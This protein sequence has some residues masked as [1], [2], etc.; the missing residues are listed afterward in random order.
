MKIAFELATE[1]ARDDERR[2]ARL[3][4]RRQTKNRSGRRLTIDLPV[5]LDRK[6]QRDPLAGF[7]DEIVRGLLGRDL[8]WLRRELED[9]LAAHPVKTE[10]GEHHGAAAAKVDRALAAPGSTMA[11]HLEQIGKVALEREGQADVMR[12][13]G[14]IA[15]RRVARERTLPR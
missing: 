12:L 13:V 10:I 6:E 14:E 9:G 11:A 3:A 8:I 15:H 4:S 1:V 2:N 7:E 5:A